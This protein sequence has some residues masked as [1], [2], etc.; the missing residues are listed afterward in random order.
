M[1]P[2]VRLVLAR[3]SNHPSL[4]DAPYV[5][6]CADYRRAGPSPSDGECDRGG[7][8]P[9]RL[10]AQDDQGEKMTSPSG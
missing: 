5:S 1:S 2:F 4:V 6:G 7:D 10:E 9:E 3:G 8:C